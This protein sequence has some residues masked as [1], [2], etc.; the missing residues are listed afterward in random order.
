MNINVTGVDGL[1]I[2]NIRC[3]FYLPEKHSGPLEMFIL[4]TKEQGRLLN[5]LENGLWKFSFIA[6]QPSIVGETAGATRQLQ[7]GASEVYSLGISTRMWGPDVE[8]IVWQAE[9]IDLRIVEVLEIYS[10]PT[11]GRFWL[12]PSFVLSPATMVK[13]SYTGDVKIEKVEEKQFELVN[14]LKLN[15]TKHYKWKVRD[16][17]DV[18]SSS[19]LVAESSIWDSPEGSTVVNDNLLESIDDFLLVASLTTRERCVCV[20]W[21]VYDEIGRTRFYRR[22]IAIPRGSTEHSHSDDLIDASHYEAFIG[23]V[24][25]QFAIDESIELMRDVLRSVSPHADSTIESRFTA[26][27]SALETLV[28]SYRRKQGLE[29][30]FTEK[31]DIAEWKKIKDKTLRDWLKAQPLRSG[32]GR[33]DQRKL[34]YENLSALERISF[35]Y[36]FRK[37]CEHYNIELSDL[38]PITG[39][40]EIL[41]SLTTIRNKLVHGEIFPSFKIGALQDATLH[42]QWTL[43]RMILGY[44]GWD[45]AKSNVALDY[46]SQ[47]FYAHKRMET[48]RTTI[49]S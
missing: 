3:K 16:D 18:L 39:G 44:F 42:L 28:L 37:Y 46:L 29:F 5:R 36:A 41:W 11:E 9:P 25:P 22:R 23:N 2:D 6:G 30:V 34:I 21:E 14:G 32:V 31:S 43:E 38:W 4:P 26:L 7:I 47:F 20:G 27:F 10:H 45:V 19:Y 48:E 24:Y 13:R 33:G 49:S 35:G 1:Q 12:T 15:F 17:G 8:E 40:G